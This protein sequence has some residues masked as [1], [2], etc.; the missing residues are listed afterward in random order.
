MNPNNKNLT[1]T[2]ENQQMLLN[3]STSKNSSR[4]YLAEHVPWTMKRPQIQ[5]KMR[6]HLNPFQFTCPTCKKED[7]LNCE[8]SFTAVQPICFW[9]L[10]HTCW[11]TISTVDLCGVLPISIYIYIYIYILIHSCPANLHLTLGQHLLTS[12]L[13]CSPIWSIVGSKIS[14]LPKTQVSKPPFSTRVIF[15]LIFLFRHW[16]TISIAFPPLAMI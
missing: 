8:H 15:R 14:L 4:I 5:P 10:D 1:T 3:N 2:K 13:H 6:W 16:E 9:F 7:H 12:N 11:S